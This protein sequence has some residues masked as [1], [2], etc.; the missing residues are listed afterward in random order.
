MIVSKTEACKERK[1]MSN[2]QRLRKQMDD[3][4]ENVSPDEFREALEAC[5]AIWTPVGMNSVNSPAEAEAVEA[6]ADFVTAID[7]EPCLVAYYG[8]DCPDNSWLSNIEA[9]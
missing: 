1:A 8:Y 9:A 3:Y 7:D 6:I 2:I 4:F 5:G